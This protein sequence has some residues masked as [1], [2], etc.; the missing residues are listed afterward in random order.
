MLHYP[1]GGGSNKDI[2]IYRIYETLILVDSHQ[3]EVVNKRATSTGGE[4]HLDIVEF[5]AVT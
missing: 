3:L 2:I 4:T 1:P 5:G